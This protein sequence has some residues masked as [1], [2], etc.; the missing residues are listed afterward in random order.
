MSAARPA[1]DVM[2]AEFIDVGDQRRGDRRARV[3]RSARGK[4]DTLF[5]ATLVSQLIPE[6]TRDGRYAAQPA[7]RPPGVVVNVRA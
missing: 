3:R 5:A 4:I 6:Q 7:L 1:S 2:D